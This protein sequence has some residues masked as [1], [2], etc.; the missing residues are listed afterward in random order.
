MRRLSALSLIAPVLVTVS[1]C[2][3]GKAGPTSGSGPTAPE[4]PSVP[5]TRF[6]LDRADL[7]GASGLTRGPDGHLFAVLERD[8]RLFE[9]ALSSGPKPEATVAG[10]RAV[11]GAPGGIDLEAVAFVDDA[12]VVFGT[13]TTKTDRAGDMLLFGEVQAD[14]VVISGEPVPLEY[15]AWGITPERNRGI[16]GLCASNGVIVAA[17]ETAGEQDGRRFAPVAT[18]DLSARAWTHYR[19][20]LTS[21]TGKLSA[22][23]CR[24]APEAIEVIAV[25]RHYEVARIVQF[26]LPRGEG[27]RDVSATVLQ[28]LAPLFGGEEKIPNYEGLTITSDGRMVAITDNDYGGI[29]GPTEILVLP[30]PSAA[31]KGATK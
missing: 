24:A 28:D 19:V 20:G 12:H 23:S 6:P 16:E 30:A 4:P 22:L 27:M 3:G 8:H 11:I 25:E 29:T 21:E 9:I 18:L 7:H 10:S 17:V 14:S 5:H 31:P 2:A 26:S 15:A 13:E 1:A